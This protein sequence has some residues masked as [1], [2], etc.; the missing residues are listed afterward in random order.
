MLNSFTRII[1]NSCDNL[2]SRVTII[3]GQHYEIHIDIRNYINVGINFGS[4]EVDVKK[5]NIK[6]F[7]PSLRRLF[8]LIDGF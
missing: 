5:E 2:S 7:I 1:F 4:F 8:Q 6:P 3:D